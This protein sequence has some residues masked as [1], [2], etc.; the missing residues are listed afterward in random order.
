[1]RLTQRYRFA[2]SH[3]LD[4]PSFTVEQNQAL[5]G[6]CNNPFG[7][8]HDYVL[9]ISVEGPLDDSGQTVNRREMDRLVHDSVI[10]HLDHKNLNADVAEFENTVPTTENL[11]SFIEGKLLENWSLPPRLARIRII[12]TARNTFDLEIA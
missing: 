5:Y 3:R 12:E 7:H 2:A 6:K 1:M 9:E 11:A 4:S 10:R 8:G